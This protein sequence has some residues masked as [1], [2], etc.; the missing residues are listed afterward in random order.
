MPIALFLSENI[1]LKIR[2]LLATAYGAS[3]GGILT[4]IGTAPNLILLGF[5]EDKGFPL[6]DFGKWVYMMSPIVAI[7]L[8]IVPLIISFGVRGE[9]VGDIGSNSIELNETQ[10]RLYLIMGLLAL[11]LIV[12]TFSKQMFGFALNEKLVLLGFGLLMFMPKVGF[13]DWEDTRDIPYEIIF[14]I[15][16]RI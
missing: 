10:K 15:W 12:N 4:P 13:L 8:L 2:F 16:S 3:I 14:P 11:L 1:R 6:V 5:L 7:M 9:S